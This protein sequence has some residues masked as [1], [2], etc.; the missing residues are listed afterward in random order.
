LV[1]DEDAE[2][3]GYVTIVRKLAIL[4]RNLEEQSMFLSRE[5]EKEAID[6]AGNLSDDE[7]DLH[8]SRSVDIPSH[9]QPSGK[10]YS[11]CEMIFEDLNN[12]CE[13]MIPI[14]TFS[15]VLFRHL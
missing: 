4:F 14:G 10:I 7:L 3:S 15:S 13:C 9:Y 2:F 11:L 12:Y 5:E 8:H 6:A 1:L